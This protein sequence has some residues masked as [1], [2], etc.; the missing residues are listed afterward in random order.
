MATNKNKAWAPQP[1]VNPINKSRKRSAYTT[2]AY[3]S[4]TAKN[5]FVDKLSDTRNAIYDMSYFKYT[6]NGARGYASSGS[7]LVDINFA[8]AS[9]RSKNGEKDA[10]IKKMFREAFKENPEYAM[11]WL[12][13]VRDIRGGLGE[14]HLFRVCMDDLARNDMEALVNA[15]VSYIPEY[16]RWDDMWELLNINSTKNA[17][18]KATK[19]QLK[20]D[21]DHFYNGKS[22][23]LLAKWLPSENTSSPI[24]KKYGAIIRKSL[25]WSPK[26]YRTTLSSLRKHIDIVERKMSSQ[27]WQAIDYETV[28][29]RANLIY[30]NAFLRNDE[31]RRRAYLGA[32]EKGE[33]KIHASVL[34]PHDIV[35]KY[36]ETTNSSLWYYNPINL[37]AY[38]SALEAMWKDLPNYNLT[39]TMVVADGSGSMTSTIGGTKVRA[40]E[41]AN[42][43]AIYCAEHC[44]GQFK[45]NYITFSH[46]PKLVNVNKDTLR[47][48]LKEAERHTE[49]ANTNIKAVF[50]LILETAIR[51]HMGQEEIPKQ[52]LI[53]SDM[54]FD[55]ACTSRPTETLFQTI[56]RMFVQA[57]YNMPKLIFW[58]V[59]SLTNTVP[60]RPHDGFPCALVSGFSPA[61]IKMVMSDKADPYEAVVDAIMDKRYDF[62]SQV[63]K[64]VC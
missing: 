6:E 39:N 53:V 57:G 52:V 44:K 40:I 58:N 18:L 54:E 38:D 32:L 10:T 2:N 26:Q 1:E 47:D 34:Y 35:H 49:V 21:I 12:F 23:S 59:H 37:K 31:T 61:I 63:M 55:G 33:A 46:T 25:K 3:K 36:Y 9:L 45:G 42:A 11:R 51:Y 27:N 4:D 7:K 50:E 5:S 56:N 16:G 29:S 43:L 41:V 17:V 22:V 13:Y 8:I 30:N 48:N 14:R 24:T 60:V 19:K 20:E 15:L 28:P 64:E 62:V